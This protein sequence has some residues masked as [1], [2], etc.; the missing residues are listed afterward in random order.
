MGDKTDYP[1]DLSTPVRHVATEL[2]RVSPGTLSITE[3]AAT[4]RH[5]NPGDIVRVRTDEDYATDE[6]AIR[7]LMVRAIEAIERRGKNGQ[8]QVIGDDGGYRLADGLTF[9]DL[10]YG[11]KKLSRARDDHVQFRDPF[12]PMSGR[13]L[14]NVRRNTGKDT[15]DELR[16]SMRSFGWLEEFPAIKD[17]RGVVLVGHRRLAVATELE[18]EPKVRMLRLGDGDEADAKRFALAIASN[19]GA[20]AFTPEERKDIAEYLYGEREWTQERIAEALQV[21]QRT[22]SSDLREL[23]VASNSKKSRG[24]RPR[25][26][27]TTRPQS[28]QAPP[29]LDAALDSKVE[30]GEPINRKELAEE[31]G[32]GDGVVYSAH[33]R[34]LGRE[35]KRQEAA[36]VVPAVAGGCT[37][38]TCGNVH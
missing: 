4:Y 7:W 13:F 14:E 12:N 19:L 6:E 18:I 25:G 35:E 2:D 24:G 32:V 29:E 15:M 26:S 37:C 38:P 11:R 21:S 16:E 10:V 9:E 36:E 8:D 31:F 30:A 23:E 3:L 28:R 34:A 5:P 1:L 22:I 33:Q 20:K 27:K 17:E